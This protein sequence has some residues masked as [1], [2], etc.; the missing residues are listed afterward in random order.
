[1]PAGKQF[2]PQNKETFRRGREGFFRLSAGS[3][4]ESFDPSVR[5]RLQGC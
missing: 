2:N 1:M 3:I 5:S 4:D